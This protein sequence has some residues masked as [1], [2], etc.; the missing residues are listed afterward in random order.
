MKYYKITN[1]QEKH[2]GMEYKTG[3]NEDVL[4]FKPSGNCDDGGI[5]FTNAE[6][7]LAFGSN[8]KWFR[9]V[10]LPEGE[11]VYK[12]PSTP[13]KW[14]AHRV[15]LGER[16]DF[17]KDICD[18]ISELTEGTMS[19]SGNL[20]LSG[21]TGITALPEGLSVSGGLY[22]N[23]CTGITALPE[24]FSVSGNL[25]L[26]GCTGITALPKGLSV[27]GFLD[28]GGCT[29]ITALPKGLSVSGRIYKNF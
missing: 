3:L 21:C 13:L 20:D 19:V 18:I 8:G 4:P 27:G 2:H 10:T 28:L 16:R 29:G 14:K 5:Y 26:S 6:N 11:D 23:G 7:I 17:E 22:L 1:E 25:D 24:G 15:I 9:E 12:N